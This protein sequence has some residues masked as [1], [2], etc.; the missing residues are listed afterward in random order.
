MALEA[1]RMWIE[2]LTRSLVTWPNRTFHKS[3][4]CKP[5]QVL[6]GIPV[7]VV[8]QALGHKVIAAKAIVTG[9]IAW[10]VFLSMYPSFVFGSAADSVPTFD[11]FGAP[12][13][14]GAWAALWSPVAVSLFFPSDSTVFQLWIQVALPLVAW[15]VCG[16]IVTRVDIGRAHRD[17]APLLRRFH[18]SAESGVGHTRTDWVP[19]CSSPQSGRSERRP[20]FYQGRRPHRPHSWK[21]CDFRLRNSAWRKCAFAEG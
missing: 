21:Y 3:R 1:L 14:M 9:C 18:S 6:K 11:Y 17:L 5:R 7:S 16:W 13:V 2:T 8:T 10:I 4:T 12:P 19:R 15:T 20:V